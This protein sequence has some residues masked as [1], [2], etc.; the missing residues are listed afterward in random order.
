VHCEPGLARATRTRE[1]QQPHVVGI[2]QAGD[3]VELGTP[4]EEGAR[5]NREVRAIEAP[6]WGELAV[7]QLEHTLGRA[8]VL[9]AVLA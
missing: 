9:E 2:E 4:A 1:R 3:L 7:T 5:R 8:Q 6:D